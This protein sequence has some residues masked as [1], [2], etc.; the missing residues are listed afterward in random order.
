MCH[1]SG[2][3]YP[4]ATRPPHGSRL[5]HSTII[6]HLPYNRW[7]MVF[8]HEL[9][10]QPRCC[11]RSHNT[12]STTSAHS[13]PRRPH[14]GLYSS[15]GERPRQPRATRTRIHTRAP[16]T[17]ITK[18]FRNHESPKKI[19]L[20]PYYYSG[21]HFERPTDHTRSNEDPR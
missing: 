10:Q 14:N 20:A 7:Q 1:R 8:S 3:A 19:N 6:A 5:K 4:Q 2:R 13:P 18:P 16:T 21:D 11:H 9:R 15:P 12:N 17:R